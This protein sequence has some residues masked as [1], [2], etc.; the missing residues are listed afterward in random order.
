MIKKIQDIKIFGTKIKQ[1]L[2]GNLQI[3][4]FVMLML[5]KDDRSENQ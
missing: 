2:K 5:E 4:M 3:Y 1:Y